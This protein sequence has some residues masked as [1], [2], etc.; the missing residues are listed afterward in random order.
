MFNH[1]IMGPVNSFEDMFQEMDE[2]DLDFWGITKHYKVDFDPFGGCE[3]GYIPEHIQSH[4]IAIRKELLVSEEFRNYWNNFPKINS[5]LEAISKHEAIFTKKFSDMGYKWNTYVQTDDIAFMNRYPL[6]YMPIELVRNR[7]CPIFKRRMF[8][9]DQAD[10]LAN[11]V[12]NTA[13]DFLKFLKE[14]DK[15]D[16]NMIWDNILRTCNQADIL[17][18]LNL[19][20]V[21][22]GKD[23]DLEKAQKIL[24]I[25][26][27]AL[28]M[29]IYFEDLIEDMCRYASYMP[30]EADIYVTTDSLKKA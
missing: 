30:S 10:I 24:A 11:T 6:M 8:F 19:R 15:F 16:V 18:C 5:Y 4:F 14:S 23:C 7:K 27:V 1:T 9:T 20:Y 3:Y 28:V 12:G 13:S 25:R 26:K 21:L 29:H 2:Q 17:R 22:S